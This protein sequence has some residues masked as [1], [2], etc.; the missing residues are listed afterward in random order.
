MTVPG[1]LW[2]TRDFR[3]KD[4]PALLAAIK[5]GPLLPVFFIDRLLTAQG[6]ASRWRLERALLS[7]DAE[8]RRRTGGT[9]VT[10]L[11]GEPDLL[12]AELVARTGARQVHQSD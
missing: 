7:F 3:F 11:R 2:L 4:N 8:L 5:R 6:A 9:G 1:I 10:I 12:L